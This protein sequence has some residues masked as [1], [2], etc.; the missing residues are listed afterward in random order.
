MCAKKISWS[1]YKFS[2]TEILQAC[3]SEQTFGNVIAVTN[4]LKFY[5]SFW[6]LAMDDALFEKKEISVRS[7][8]YGWFC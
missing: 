6:Y 1:Q 5:E 7:L 3:F 2:I 8:Y 4:T